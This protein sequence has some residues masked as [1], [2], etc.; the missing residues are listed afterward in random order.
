MT[1]PQRGSPMKAPV[2]AWGFRRHH[3]ALAPTGRLYLHMPSERQD[4]GE[5]EGRP[6]GATETF[7][8]PIIRPQGDAL[9]ILHIFSGRYTGT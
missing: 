6:V 7:R 4:C 1:T 9:F 2:N 8:Y 3:L 5:H